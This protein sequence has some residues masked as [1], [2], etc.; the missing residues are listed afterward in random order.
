MHYKIIRTQRFKN[1]FRGVV[2]FIAKDKKSAAKSFKSTLNKSIDDLPNFPYKYRKSIYF[3][4]DNI[5]DMT[6]MG[7]TIIYEIFEN[8][9]EVMMI[10]NQNK[11]AT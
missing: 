1:Q 7:Y 5:R 2:F 3:E 4:N 10:F 11:P 9:I 8:K 6:F